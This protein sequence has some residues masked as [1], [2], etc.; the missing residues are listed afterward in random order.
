MNRGIL[1]NFLLWFASL[2]PVFVFAQQK[3][4]PEVPEEVER[5][6]EDIT[7]NNEDEMPDDDS[8]LQDLEFF[9]RHPVNLNSVDRET[10]VRLHM[11]T[12]AQ[13]DHF[14]SYRNVFGNFLSVYEL[15][16][17]PLWDVI[18]IRRLLPYITI[19]E[20][21]SVSKL[22]S[23]F[24]DGD[25]SV[26]LRHTRVLELSE[27]FT[28]DTAGG[29]SY[30]PGSPDK[31]L[32][33]YRYRFRNKLQYGI[34]AEKDAG[35]QFFKGNQPYGFDYYSAHFFARDIGIIKALVV[36][37]FAVNFG[38]GLVQ[39]QSLSFS[40]PGDALFL[41]KQGEKLRPYV[42]A[43]EVAFNRGIGMTI[44]KKRWQ[45][46][47]YG[48]FRSMDATAGYDTVESVASIRLS[49]YHRTNSEI[50][51]KNLLNQF[52]M[53]GNLQYTGNNFRVGMNAA[54]FYF[55]STITRSGD[56][57]NKF[58][59]PGKRS[60]NYSVDYSY[61]YK[62]IHLFGEIAVDG[63]L[64]VAY[65]NG[66]GLS[67]SRYV[68][69]SVLHRHISPKY[70]TLYGS[71][72][73]ESSSPVN[74]SGLYTGI[75]IRPNDFIRIDAY[76][77]VFRFPWLR[78]RVD[79]PSSGTAY[80]LQFSYQPSRQ[81]AFYLRYR[82]TDKAINTKPEGQALNVVANKIKESVRAHAS[83]KI[84]SSFTF[85][86]RVEVNWYDSKPGFLIYA[87]VIYKPLMKNLSGNVR[88]QY[89]ETE[90]YDSRIYTFENDV[91]YSYSIPAFFG[92]GFR[93]YLNVRYN[94]FRDVSLWMR[95]AQ[96]WYPDQ[97]EIGSG[98]DKINGNKKTELKTELVWRF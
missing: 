3:P 48:S 60:S 90:D 56:L 70:L 33:R 68:D 94:I 73:T 92:K 6:L 89:F 35:E 34:T 54:Q 46:T 55:N 76:A 39:W 61:T 42:S 27:G 1:K 10:L 12:P 29:K 96:S 2:I 98:L 85:R 31:V 97:T 21:E 17:I 91:L 78:Y 72:F 22:I 11:L 36:G 58:I 24:K 30:Y 50:D 9:A 84:N 15:Q 63:D 75:N 25:H 32:L 88:L 38:Q 52:S 71:A 77:D 66:A 4:S 82:R 80:M 7:A 43:G 44:E 19:T 79:A 40:G 81:A 14:I 83:L 95:I 62:N 47:F 28:R 26:L 74:E 20:K 49:G 86:S 8:Y 5:R 45:G 13:I 18:T 41:K 51:G 93:Y 23:R 57:Y 16:A 69:V 37:D 87:D 65:L 64:D 59:V 53:G 67:A